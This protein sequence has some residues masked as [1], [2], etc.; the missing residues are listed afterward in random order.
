MQYRSDIDGLRALAVLMVVVYHFKNNIGFNGFMGVDIF[1]V[2]SGFLITKIIYHEIT[3]NVFSLQKFYERRVRRIFPTLFAVIFVTTLVAFALFLPEELLAF[4]KSAITGLF[5]ASNILFYTEAGYFDASADLKPLLHTWSLAVEEQ[6]YI[7]FPLLLLVILKY[8]KTHLKLIIIGS[9]FLSFIIAFYSERGGLES[10]AFFML[11]MRVW[12]FLA[13]A[14]IALNIVHFKNLSNMTLQA[15]SF[16]G[17]GLII[18]GV[19]IDLKDGIVFSLSVLPVVLGTA[20]LIYA[21]QFSSSLLINKMLGARYLT[22]FGKISYSLYLWHWPIYVFAMYYTLNDLS[23]IDRGVL[24]L[25][26]VFIAYLSW[27]FIEQPFRRKECKIF[28]VKILSLGLS[29]A[30]IVLVISCYVVSKAGKTF[31]HS[32][33]TIRITDTKL[34]VDFPSVQVL[35][36]KYSKGISNLLLGTSSSVD[37]ASVLLLGDSH[38]RT[39]SFAVDKQAKKYGKTALAFHNGCF[40]Q[41]EFAAQSKSLEECGNLTEEQLNY[42][43]ENKNIDTV[44]IALRWANKTENF[45]IN[46]N[47]PKKDYLNFR[48]E[49]LVSFINALEEKNIDTV[50]VAQVPL[51]DLKVD[52]FPSIYARMLQRNDEGLKNLNPTVKGYYNHQKN[53]LPIWEYIQ[54]NTTAKILWPHKILC[55]ETICAIGD[56]SNLYYWDDDHLSEYGADFVSPIFEDVFMKGARP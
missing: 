30:T 34:G 37:D 11:P 2:I 3:N 55:G 26:S 19:S 1:F 48:R 43:E 44:I 16:I 18:M 29:I 35:S 47:I 33:E 9:F 8:L 40:L 5:F 14:M 38:A 15:L 49:S 41:K 22:F 46:H 17:L 31:L 10:L 51:L 32:A 25:I 56:G 6:F 23:K 28:S 42:I 13:G 4:S 52:N 12:E 21:G 20:L 45:I 36:N 24:I 54:E 53:I 27:R 7:I 50:I 39:L